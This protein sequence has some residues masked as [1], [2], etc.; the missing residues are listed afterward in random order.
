MFF[1]AID[2]KIINIKF[3]QWQLRCNKL[4]LVIKE[5]QEAKTSDTSD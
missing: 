1:I 3:L 2:C 5:T 4:K